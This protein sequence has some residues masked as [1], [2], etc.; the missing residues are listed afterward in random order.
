M[1][2]LEC[3]SSVIDQNDIGRRIRKIAHLQLACCRR[4]TTFAS[5]A[6]E[7]EVSHSDVRSIK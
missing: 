4:L 5:Q 1:G 7:A 6:N 2:R 3:N